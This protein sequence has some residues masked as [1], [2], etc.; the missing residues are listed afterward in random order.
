MRKLVTADVFSLC[1]CLKKIGVK[2]QFRTI[3]QEADTAADVWDKG[4][5]LIWGLFD[6]ATEA[7]GE[8]E[9]YNFLSGP[10]E[11]AP[12]EVQQLPL[13]ELLDN[14]RQLVTENNLGI[15]FKSAARL[16]K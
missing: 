15:F 1:R 14:M 5:D 3:A 16:M 10:F 7:N 4:F 13:D 9:V 12:E 2:D 6:V 8:Q 11:M